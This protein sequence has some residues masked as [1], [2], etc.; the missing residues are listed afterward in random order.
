MNFIILRAASATSSADQ[1][2]RVC[3]PIGCYNSMHTLLANQKTES[4]CTQSGASCAKDNKIHSGLSL[5][6]SKKNF[7]P[8]KYFDPKIFLT[9]MII[10]NQK[11]FDLFYLNNLLNKKKSILHSSSLSPSELG[12]AQPQLVQS[13]CFKRVSLVQGLFVAWQ[14]SLRII[15][16]F[17]IKHSA[18]LKNPSL[19]LPSLAKRLRLIMLGWF[20]WIRTSIHYGR[21]RRSHWAIL[22]KPALSLV[23]LRVLYKNCV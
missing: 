13:L 19:K 4:F 6:S 9:K 3:I 11:F 10:L 18:K 21:R 16:Y 8:K 17:W 1:L 20:V 12:T 5:F 23:S 7:W 14:S 22:P 15:F 2:I